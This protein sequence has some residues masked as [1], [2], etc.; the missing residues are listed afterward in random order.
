M[1]NLIPP[2]GQKVLKREYIFRVGGTIAGL[3][4]VVCLL[5]SVALV[6]T[7]VLIGA[8]IK[9][10]LAEV[11]KEGGENEA[12]V[13]ADEEVKETKALIRQLKTFAPTLSMSDVVEEIT[14]VAPGGILFRTFLVEDKAGKILNI[15]AQ[16]TAS[17]REVLA[18]L[19]SALE[20][21]PLFEEA[22]VPIADLARDVN[23]P[24]TITITLE[25]PQ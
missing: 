19:K 8:Q 14:H 25:E 20:A 18:Q 22:E 15:Q 16:G 2:E 24:F 17:T 3:F 1:I 11:E 6:P 7:Y 5:L 10:S 12:F 23:L 13:K 4:G 21:S 9:G